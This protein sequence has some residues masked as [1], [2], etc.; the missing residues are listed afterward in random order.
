MAPALGS[1]PSTREA[2]IEVL[3]PGVHLA[4]LQLLQTFEKQI[5]LWVD[6]VSRSLSLSN[7]HKINE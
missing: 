3:V 1:L 7:K 5:S 6:S 4:W 2:R